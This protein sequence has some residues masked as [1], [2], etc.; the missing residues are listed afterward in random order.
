MSS[1]ITTVAEAV[2]SELNAAAEG[3]FGL[4]FTAQRVYLPEKDLPELVDL[5]VCVVPK[6][7]ETAM[8]GRNMIQHDVSIDIGVRKKLSASTAAGSD[9]VELDGLSELV[10]QI[11]GYLRLRPLAGVA[12]A[13]WIGSSV[14]PIYAVEHLRELR[15]FT[16]VLTVIYRVMES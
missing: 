14:N 1:I 3:T 8:A 10:E 12:L 13:R 6:G 16:S 2:A 4:E 5:S 7:I 11:A 9:H 15:Q